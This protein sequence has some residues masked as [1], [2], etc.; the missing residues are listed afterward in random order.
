MWV[1]SLSTKCRLSIV[2]LV[3]GKKSRKITQ[4]ASQLLVRA[5]LLSSCKL[6]KNR[7]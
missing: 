2:S 7:V 6:P 1:V 3:W 4:A 5:D